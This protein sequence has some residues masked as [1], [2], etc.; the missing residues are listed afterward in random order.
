L[1]DFFQGQGIHIGTLFSEEL[2]PPMIIAR[3]ERRSGSVSDVVSDDRFLHPVI[4]SVSTI[5]DGVDAD[6]MGEELQEAVRVAL[7]QAH[8]QQTVVPNGGSIARITN[9][10]MPVRVSD[11]ATSTGIVQYASLPAGQVRYES[12]WRLI[13]RSPPQSTITNR[14]LITP[15]Q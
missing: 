10:S 4:V 1:Q 11:Y 7:R 5:T 8:L 2:N 14:F 9:A 6:E 15:G 12:V 13:L 3:A